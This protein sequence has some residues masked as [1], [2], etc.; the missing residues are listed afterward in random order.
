[1]NKTTF[2]KDVAMTILSQIEATYG[3]TINIAGK[4]HRISA[5][6]IMGAKMIVYGKDFVQFVVQGAPDFNKFVIK[7]NEKDLYDIEMWNVR[8][9]EDFVCEKV[10]EYNDIYAE[11][12]GN[13]LVKEVLYR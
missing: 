12:L 13:L 8:I 6:K 5:M 3:A 9:G 10:D 7:L 4:I 1:M 11:Q 2:E